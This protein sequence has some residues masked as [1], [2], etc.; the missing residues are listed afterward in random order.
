MDNQ[1]AEHGESID[2]FLQQ[3]C[4]RAD[5]KI[6]LFPEE[7]VRSRVEREV[8]LR[9]DV[10]PDVLSPA[11]AQDVRELER[12]TIA[13][14]PRTFATD[15]VALIEQLS[16][17]LRQVSARSFELAFINAPGSLNPQNDRIVIGVRYLV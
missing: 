15:T 10:N 5:Q 11:R 9:A 6:V 12:R 13:A 3:F 14:D 2:T 8:A 17:E 4:R 16:T 1:P 7:L